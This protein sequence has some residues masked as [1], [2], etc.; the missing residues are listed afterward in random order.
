MN[1]ILANTKPLSIMNCSPFF[2]AG[3]HSKEIA[4]HAKYSKAKTKKGVMCI[5]GRSLMR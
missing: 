2:G 4:Y 5:L 1:A 3:D